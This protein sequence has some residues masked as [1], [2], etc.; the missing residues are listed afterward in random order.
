M[1]K[2]K[3]EK[4]KRKNSLGRGKG[5]GRGRG[6]GRGKGRGKGRG[7]ASD[8]PEQVSEPVPPPAS[9]VSEPVPLALDDVKEE[10]EEH[11]SPQMEEHEEHE[12]PHMEEHDEHK[13]P[14]MEEHQEH[15]SPQMEE[16]EEH[17][18]PQMEEH[19]EHVSPHMEEHLEHEPPRMELDE[20]AGPVVA[21]PAGGGPAA[22]PA[23]AAEPAAEPPA[24][25]AA[26]ERRRHVVLVSPREHFTPAVLQR[27]APPGMSFGL[28][29]KAHRFTIKFKVKPQEGHVWAAY[30]PGGSRSKAFQHMPWEEALKE[31]HQE[32]WERWDLAKHLS[33]FELD[34]PNH[35]QQPGHVSDSMLAL[36]REVIENMP[37][38]TKYPKR[39]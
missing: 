17:E 16:H 11:K 24:E 22:D 35:V 21:G 31:L 7:R 32:A 39:F 37:P 12:S 13:S 8:R 33:G 27:L 38:P 15:E 6:R 25:P 28:D 10:H 19:E 2:E 3:E 9:S 4:K 30:G 20:A 5:R 1:S 14:Q 29:Q 18:S 26:A 23:P 36:I 34:D